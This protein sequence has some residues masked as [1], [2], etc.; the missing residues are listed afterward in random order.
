MVG[1]VGVVGFRIRVDWM[2]GEVVVGCALVLVVD[3]EAARGIFGR[4]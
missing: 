4:N 1:G 2:M 3:L